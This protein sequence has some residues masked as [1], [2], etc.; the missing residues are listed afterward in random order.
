MSFPGR[1]Q[2]LFGKNDASSKKNQTKRLNSFYYEE[3][4]DGDDNSN[5]NNN[6]LS[7]NNLTIDFENPN[8]NSAVKALQASNNT[9]RKSS[10]GSWSFWTDGS[11]STSKFGL[12]SKS[13]TSSQSDTY[14]VGIGADKKLS[15]KKKVVLYGELR[16]RTCFVGL[17]VCMYV[18][19]F[20]CMYGRKGARNTDETK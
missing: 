8:L 6:N 5:K 18:C 16:R 3:G 10:N 9:N 7:A 12:T 15:N 20:V 4:F 1:A 13:T 19:L 17:E 14:S 2:E 11:I